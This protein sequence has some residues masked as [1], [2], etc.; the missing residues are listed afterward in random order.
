MTPS[1][2]SPAPRVAE[3]AGG[4]LADRI[5]ELLVDAL[6]LD[7]LDLGS[8]DLS[9]PLLGD[10]L[11]LDSIDVLELVVALEREFG[12]VVPTEEVASDTFESVGSVVSLVER[13]RPAA[14]GGR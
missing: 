14:G 5:R 11:G 1:S 9:T 8:L 2:P 6:R 12:I 4:E 3:A 10:G 13:L 7:G